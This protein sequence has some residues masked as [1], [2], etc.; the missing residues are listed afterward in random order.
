[1]RIKVFI[2]ERLMYVMQWVS[3]VTAAPGRIA[4]N[5]LLAFMRIKLGFLPCSGRSLG[6]TLLAT[7]VLST[8]GCA[9]LDAKQRNII[10]RPTP[11]VP[12]DFAGLRPGD[13]RYF[14]SVPAAAGQGADARSAASDPNATQPPQ[15]EMWWLPHT[16]PTAPTLLYYHG[17]FRNLYQNLPKINALRE[18]GFAILAVEYRGWGRSSAI[19]PSEQTIVQDARI[20][21]N[22]LQRRELRLSHRVIYGHSMGSGVAVEIASRLTAP[23]DYGGLILESAFTSFPDIATEASWL[24]RLVSS[25]NNERFASIDKIG[26]VQAPLLMMH[27]TADK[28]VPIQ[29]G[30]RLFTAAQAPKEWRPIEGGGHSNLQDIGKEDYQ[31]ALVDFRKRLVSGK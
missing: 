1:M 10:Y 22:E 3:S 15:I 9:W 30:E 12:A 19:V 23:A 29:L 27:G 13:E 31:K 26:K 4:R 5:P 24:G 28:T 17:T 18:A 7:L 8:S 6:L 20:A 21:F 14:L 2:T 25:F 11:G 16:D